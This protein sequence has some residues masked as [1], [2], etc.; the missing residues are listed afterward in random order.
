MV[1]FTFF[2]L[3]SL[4]SQSSIFHFRFIFLMGKIKKYAK[5]LKNDLQS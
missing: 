1:R 3:V 4:N 2:K 5:S